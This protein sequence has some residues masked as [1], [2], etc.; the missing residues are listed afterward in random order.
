MFLPHGIVNS[1]KHMPADMI[2]ADS[3]SD[4]D[5]TLPC[6]PCHSTAY[7]GVFSG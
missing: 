6:A 5:A 1:Q 7:V 3:V 2:Q 4:I